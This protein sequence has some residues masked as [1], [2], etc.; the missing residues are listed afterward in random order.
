MKIPKHPSRFNNIFT[1][2]ELTGKENLRF[3]TRQPGNL[4]LNSINA[5]KNLN[6]NKKFYKISEEQKQRL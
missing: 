1:A 6:S 3:S 5:Y 2:F 4:F